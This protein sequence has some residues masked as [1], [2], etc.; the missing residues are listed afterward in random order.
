MT[1]LVL[2]KTG[3]RQLSDIELV[4]Y[5][6]THCQTERALF[7][8]EDVNRMLHLAGCPEDF[9]SYLPPKVFVTVREEMAMLCRL[10]ADRLGLDGKTLPAQ[11]AA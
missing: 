4:R 6:E 1:N 10:A 11:K 3:R 5:C 7:S 9:A 2:Q 8:G